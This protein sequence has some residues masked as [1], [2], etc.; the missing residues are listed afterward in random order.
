MDIKLTEVLVWAIVGAVAGSLAGA[1][2][3][4]KKEGY[5][6]TVN[7][8][9]G[10]TGAAIGGFLFRLGRID[11]GL[12]SVHVRVDDM[13]SAIVGSFVFLG[14]VGFLQREDKKS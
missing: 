9:I 8:I 12:G 4:R 14:L 13:V 1:I 6:H 5:G 3:K 11:L 10:I 7:L 2:V